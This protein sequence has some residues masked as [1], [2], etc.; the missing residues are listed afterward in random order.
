MGAQWVAADPAIAAATSGDTVTHSIV[1]RMAQ[2]VE[3]LRAMEEEAGGGDFLESART[4]LRLITGMLENGRYTED[5]ARRLYT[6]AAEV[7]CLLGWMSYDASLHSAAQQHYNVGLRAAKLAGDDTLGAHI[8]CFMA[9]Q[10]TNQ[11]EQSAAVGL[12]DAA[13][14]VRTRVPA[15][16]RV[17]LAGHQTTVYSQAGDNR[18]AAEALNRAFDALEQVDDADIPPYLRWIGEGQ[19]GSTEGRYFLIS[20]QAARATEALERSVSRSTPR[21]RAVRYGTLALAYRRTGDLDGALDAT[22]KAADLIDQGIHTQRGIERL[23]EVRTAIATHRSEPRVR[24]AMERITTL[25]A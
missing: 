12:V 3:S 2:R 1:D 15:V 18:R 19:L 9:T 14:A 4:D 7:C 10:A 20:G 24:E 8:L 16:M 13:D 5:I 21:D 11:R 17:S 22:H 23:H 6:L 25:A